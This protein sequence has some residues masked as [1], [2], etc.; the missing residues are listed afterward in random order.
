MYES[1]KMFFWK[2]NVNFFC[3][4]MNRFTDKKTLQR[5]TT[6][7]PLIKQ[8]NKIVLKMKYGYYAYYDKIKVIQKGM[9]YWLMPLLN[10]I[11]LAT[12]DF[13]LKCT[14]I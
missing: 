12:Y 5:R 1:K 8:G 7:C 13:S 11:K 2:Q 9:V 3:Y 14:E 10:S 6:I 4:L